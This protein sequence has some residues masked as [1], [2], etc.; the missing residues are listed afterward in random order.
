MTML[1]DLRFPNW[2]WTDI[3]TLTGL[4]VGTPL[5]IANKVPQHDLLIWLG[6]TAP[7]IAPPDSVASQDG[8]TVRYGSPA[9]V[10]AGS[11]RDWLMLLQLTGS[12]PIHARVS[13]Q[14]DV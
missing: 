4:A 3:N 8:Y 1:A 12:T 11:D 5:V 14:E 7:A 9:R 6:P 13:V 2:T 10:K